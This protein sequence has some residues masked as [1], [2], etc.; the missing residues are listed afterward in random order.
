MLNQKT[1]RKHKKHK[2]NSER[3]LLGPPK[4]RRIRKPKKPWEKKKKKTILGKSWGKGGPAKSLWELFFLFFL[5]FPRFFWFSQRVFFF[6]FFLVFPRFFWFFVF[7]WFWGVQPRVSQNCFFSL[8][9]FPWFLV[10]FVFFLCVFYPLCIFISVFWFWLWHWCIYLIFM[11]MYGKP[12]PRP[13]GHPWCAVEIVRIIYRA[14]TTS[15]VE[16]GWGGRLGPT[17]FWGWFESQGG[18]ASSLRSSI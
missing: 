11:K 17:T 9:V 7:F 3:L 14:P 5:V 16:G 4:I 15:D 2:N 18:I 6:L 10:L 13:H 1:L 8:F 12:K